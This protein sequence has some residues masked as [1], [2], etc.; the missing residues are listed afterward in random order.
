M[1]K[2]LEQFKKL[3]GS[4]YKLAGG[5]MLVEIL[6]KK[7]MKTSGGLIMSA[8][9]NHKNVADTQRAV[10]GVVLMTGEG[11]VDDDGN[12]I[13]METKVGAVVVLNEF[14]LKYYSEFP[15]IATY[16]ESKLALTAESEIQMKFDS[17]DD[18][19]EFER[20]LNE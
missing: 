13:E 15:G 6:A 16:T 20:I 10:V 11:Y 14:G 9:L 5:R 8:P 18:L 7:E 4:K 12:E 19:A 2:Y 3:E 17:F 1:T